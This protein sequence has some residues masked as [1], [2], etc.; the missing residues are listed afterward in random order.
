M[1]GGKPFFPLKS[2]VEWSDLLITP[3]NNLPFTTDW[4]KRM[5]NSEQWT[6]WGKGGIGGW[7]GFDCCVC[8]SGM[9]DGLAY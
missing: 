5:K 2:A 7:E 4:S 8:C 9:A 6:G 1:W 3:S